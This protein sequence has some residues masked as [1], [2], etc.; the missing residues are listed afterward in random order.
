MITQARIM[1]VEDEEIVADDIRTSL[2]KMG[3]AVC[4][5]AA[6]GEEAVKKAVETR[7]DLVL[8][9]IML[10]GAMD[11]TQAA[12][13]IRAQ[14][15]IPVIY[16]TAYADGETL[17]R[18]KITEPYGYIIKPFQDR[19]VQIAIEIALYKSRA[20]EEIKRVERESR[21]QLV[22]NMI[23]AIDVISAIIEMKGPF[24]PGHHQRVSEMGVAIA[25][26][27]GLEDSQIAGIER[28]ARLYDIGLLG[29]PLEFLQDVGRLDGIK[30][31]L[32]QNHPQVG[33]DLLKNIDFP[34][35]VADIIHQYRE[36][37]DGTGFPR[38]LR[39]SDILMEAR[40]FAVADAIEDLTVN[41][42]YRNAFPINQA[43]AEITAQ[44]G[45]KY[46]PE[47]VDACLK[48]FGSANPPA[49]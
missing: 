21:A 28:S 8:S 18:A 26:E 38:G 48:L 13:Q 47:V 42:S 5:V 16:L 44:R 35:P 34:W 40:I 6:T 43:M 41:K 24:I 27:M 17:E 25:R 49:T 15:N 20:E 1:I 7:P 12:E 9:D 19:E 39:G 33:Y 22:R 14:V 45:S 32:Y 29:I 30:L 2:E 3:Y 23:G 37:Y 11:G 46:D 36:C 10:Q 31:T 4:A